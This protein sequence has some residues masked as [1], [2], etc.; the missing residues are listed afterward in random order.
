MINIDEELKQALKDKDSLKLSTLRRLKNTLSSYA[1]SC[2]GNIQAELSESE[3]LSNIRKLIK[4]GQD[5]ISSFSGREDLIQKEQREIAILEKFLPLSLTNDEIDAIVA[6]AI[7]QSGAKSKKE[8]GAA[9]KIASSLAA[10]KVDGKTLS[11]KISA[12]LC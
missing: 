2:K 3:I 10:G 5:S 8:M 11:T 1:L 9:M 12:L 6:S 7:L 4:Q